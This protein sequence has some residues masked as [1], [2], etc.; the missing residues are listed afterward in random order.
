MAVK[1]TVLDWIALILVIVGAINWGL[2]GLLN[3]DFVTYLLGA[4]TLTQIV[5][6]LVGLA[7]L[8]MIYFAT[9]KK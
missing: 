5:Y 8:Y 2:V 1:K 6:V 4:G 7:G 9:K 3:V